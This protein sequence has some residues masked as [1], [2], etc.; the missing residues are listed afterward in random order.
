MPSQ[1]SLREQQ[2]YAHPQN[3]FWP[4]WARLLGTQ[5]PPSYAQR[6][7]MLKQA[8][9][10]VWDVLAE[11]QR[12]GSLDASIVP[13]SVRCNDISKL[14]TSHPTIRIIGCNGGFAARTFQRQMLPTLHVA[15]AWVSLP[16]TSP[17]NARWRLPDLVERWAEQL[18]LTHPE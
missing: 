3:R 4:L 17:A 1:A 18:Q 5:L 2:Y 14:L 16:S 9:V 13:D 6:V 10:A 7:D 15:V 8:G 12:P 11:C